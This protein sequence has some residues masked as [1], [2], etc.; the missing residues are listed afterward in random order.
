[1]HRLYWRLL[2]RPSLGKIMLLMGFIVAR[3]LFEVLRIALMIPLLSVLLESKDVRSEA[4]LRILRDI[5]EYI[6]LGRGDAVVLPTIGILL[7]GSVLLDKG[8]SLFLIVVTTRIQGS[9]RVMLL[10]RMFDSFL[11]ARYHE[12]IRRGRAGIHQDLTAG[13]S[14]SRLVTIMSNSISSLMMVILLSS[15][16]LFLSWETTVI[17]AVVFIPVTVLIRR[18]FEGPNRELSR[19][20]HELGQLRTLRLFDAIDGI[21]VAKM[22]GL[23]KHLVKEVQDNENRLVDVQ[24]KSG[25]ILSIPN[26]VNEIVGVSLI[27][28]LLFLT[29]YVPYFGLSLPIVV[30]QILAL[31]RMIPAVSSLGSMLMQLSANYKQ[32]MVVGEVLEDIEWEDEDGIDLS[33]RV[34]IHTVEFRSVSFAYSERPSEFVL[35]DVSFGLR[36]GKV[37]A[38]VGS[39]GAGKTTLADLLVRLYSPSSGE[40]LVNGINV[41]NLRLSTW[42]SQIGYVG[43]DT[44][45]FNGTLWD[46]LVLWHDGIEAE[47][48]ERAARDA[49][50]HSFITSL[51]EGYN[52]LVGDRGIKLSG[53]QRQRVAIA[54]SILHKP[55]VLIFDEATSALDNITEAEVQRA[56]SNLRDDA[57]VLIIAHRLSTVREADEI[58]VLKSGTVVERGQHDALMEENGVYAQLYNSEVGNESSDL[59]DNQRESLVPI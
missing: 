43:Q 15:L 14:V 25:L 23:R 44:F 16:L 48:V 29:F 12:V 28:F 41:D 33:P 31:T 6:G 53:G 1:M 13:G 42:R 45:L 39:T 7:L 20:K 5:T 2:L 59:L 11:S 26:V 52:T 18:L 8:L 21:K 32:I 54:R 4:A 46:N 36:R 35:D 49:L 56:I 17:A 51:P 40:I 38:I 58:V 47:H 22:R 37:T 50:I 9:V 57:V 19:R 34:G 30:P 10:S 27:L 24:V 55:Q 3:S